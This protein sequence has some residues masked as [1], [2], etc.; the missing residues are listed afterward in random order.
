MYYF[1]FKL[2]C[3]VTQGLKKARLIWQFPFKQAKNIMSE[4]FAK[5][6]LILDSEHQKP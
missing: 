6:G 5:D 4:R 2:P 1:H 3:E